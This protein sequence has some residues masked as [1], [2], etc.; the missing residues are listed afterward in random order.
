MSSRTLFN[1]L[2]VKNNVLVTKVLP[3]PY[4]YKLSICQQFSLDMKQAEFIETSQIQFEGYLNAYLFHQV[5]NKC[6]MNLSRDCLLTNL[7]ALDLNLLGFESH[8]LNQPSNHLKTIYY[9]F[10]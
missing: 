1:N 4:T 8:K 7:K 10:Q 5:A 2:I 3:N 6:D 9:S